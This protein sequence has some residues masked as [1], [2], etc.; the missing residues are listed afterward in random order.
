MMFRNVFFSLTIFACMSAAVS[1]AIPLEGVPGLDN[2]H[3][4][5]NQSSN[6]IR[7]QPLAN[8]GTDQICIFCHTPHSATPDS[9]LWS[10]PAPAAVGPIPQ[11]RLA[12]ANII[13]Q[14][15]T[16]ME[17]HVCVSRVTMASQRSGC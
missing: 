1:F 16:P 12:V 10:R 13:Q 7:A 4:L 8:D 11:A 3:N 5:S 14:T 17:R 15:S 2:K 9:P 6:I